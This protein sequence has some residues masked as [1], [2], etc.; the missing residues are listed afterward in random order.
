MKRMA[1]WV[2]GQL[3]SRSPQTL[4]VPARVMGKSIEQLSGE[5]GPGPKGPDLESVLP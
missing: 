4:L 2:D 1:Q 5:I 3:A